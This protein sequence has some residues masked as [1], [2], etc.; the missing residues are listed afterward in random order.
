MRSQIN[1]K[2]F[3]WDGISAHLILNQFPIDHAMMYILK[4]HAH[5]DHDNIS[6]V[7]KYEGRI[8][9]II[10][11]FLSLCEVLSSMSI[12]KWLSLLLDM[13]QIWLAQPGPIRTQRN[14]S[15]KAGRLIKHEPHAFW[16]AQA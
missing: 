7:N 10:A 9:L 2:V 13:A 14:Q 16:L 4:Y 15:G 11:P 5:N 12:I 6:A 8:A 3:V 1:L